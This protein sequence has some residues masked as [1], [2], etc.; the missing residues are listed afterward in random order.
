MKLFQKAKLVLILPVVA[1]LASAAFAFD[2]STLENSV[3]EHTLKNGLKILI[4]ERHDAPVVSF[5]TYADVG[6][7]DDPKGY[8]GIAHMFEHMAFKGTTTFGTKD[9]AKEKELIKIDDKIKEIK[10][11]KQAV[12]CI[13]VKFPLG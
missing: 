2:F 3:V 11:T 8:T 7:V 6:S 10:W 13:S 12:D 4:L 1:I 5:N 9:Y